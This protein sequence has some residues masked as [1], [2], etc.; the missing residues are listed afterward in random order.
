MTQVFL[1]TIF[2]A[3]ALTVIFSL[4]FAWEKLVDMAEARGINTDLIFFGS[5]VSAGLGWLITFIPYG[6][7]VGM[8]IMVP[9]IAVEVACSVL[10]LG[11]ILGCCIEGG[12]CFV[13]GIGQEVV[14]FT[15]RTF[16]RLMRRSSVVISA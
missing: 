15:T 3:I 14:I 2:S 7:F 13:L 1:Y 16:N 6:Q 10:L 5:M 4:R 12:G 8:A 9:S 11:G